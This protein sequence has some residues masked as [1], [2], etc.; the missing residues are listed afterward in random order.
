MEP[1]IKVKKLQTHNGIKQS[2]QNFEYSVYQMNG[3]PDDLVQ[4][5]QQRSSTE[6]NLNLKDNLRSTAIHNNYFPG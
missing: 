6:N 4:V 1:V 3:N 2:T 5:D